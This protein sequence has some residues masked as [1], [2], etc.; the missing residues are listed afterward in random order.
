MDSNSLTFA[1]K[2][3]LIR[4]TNCIVAD[5]VKISFKDEE[6][7]SRRCPLLGDDVTGGIGLPFECQ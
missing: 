6:Q 7:A 3:R 2:D 1:I 5:E 4:L